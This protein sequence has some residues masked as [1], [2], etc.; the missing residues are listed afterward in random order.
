MSAA[1]TPG[2][3]DLSGLKDDWNR[4][5]GLRRAEHSEDAPA[6]PAPEQPA[7]PPAPTK[8]R[9]TPTAAVPSGQEEPTMS[10]R[11]WY[12]EQE[13]VEALAEVVDDIHYAT[14]KPKH[15]VVSELFR[16]AVAAAPRVQKKLSK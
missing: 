16:A 13:A 4:M 8:K 2:P 12:A 9:R 1:A 3:P 5:S 10:R 7:A 15:Q 11:S 6:Q 14:R